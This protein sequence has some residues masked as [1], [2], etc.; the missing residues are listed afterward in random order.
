MLTNVFPFV[1]NLTAHS[2]GAN[3][4]PASGTISSAFDEEVGQL[5][6]FL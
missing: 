6:T 4:F 2:D 1:N 3:A 5:E